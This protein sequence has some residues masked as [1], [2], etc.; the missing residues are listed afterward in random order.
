MTIAP[1]VPIEISANL[2]VVDRNVLARSTDTIPDAADRMDEWIAL[3]AVD[4]AAHAPNVDIDDV[5]RRVEMKIPYVLQQHRPRDDVACV[6]N[7]IL[8]K[9]EFPGQHFDVT[10][11]PPDGSRH[12]IHLE[13]A[14]AQ[15][16]FLDHRRAA[17]GKGLD[18]GQ[19]F[20]EGEW[21]DEIVV[22]AGAQSPYPIVDLAQSADDQNRR[23]DAVVPQA[24]HNG[25]AIDVG[26]HAID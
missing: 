25:D 22:A 2:N 4:L 19:Q 12:E 17:P 24:S 5:G 6:A 11:A 1:K 26:K 21:L 10:A 23:S 3:L 7:Q 15:D 14:D 8:E 18:T 9:L 20:G 16:G 13:I